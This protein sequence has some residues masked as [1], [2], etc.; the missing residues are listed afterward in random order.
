MDVKA[1]LFFY[2]VKEL[3][4][5][6]SCTSSYIVD[7]MHISDQLFVTAHS[8]GTKDADTPKLLCGDR[9]Q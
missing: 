3:L 4:Y 9:N 2:E 6:T 7:V 8:Q 1:S 5:R